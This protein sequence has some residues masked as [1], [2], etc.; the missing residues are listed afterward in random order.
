MTKLAEAQAALPEY[1][2]RMTEVGVMATHG[3][4]YLGIIPAHTAKYAICVIWPGGGRSRALSLMDVSIGGE[5][6]TLREAHD[7]AWE[8]FATVCAN[9]NKTFGGRD[10][11]TPTA[12]KK[13]GA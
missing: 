5:G 2:W 13:A 4:T 7:A 10:A 6:D 8:K 1:K 12:A 9:I 11:E 3:Q